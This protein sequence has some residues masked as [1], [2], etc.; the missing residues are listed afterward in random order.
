MPRLFMA[1]TP[2]NGKAQEHSVGRTLAAIPKSAIQTSPGLTPRIFLLHP[3]EHQRA[4]ERSLV[5]Q[6]HIGVLIGDFQQPLPYGP[7]LGFTQLREFLNDFRCAHGEIVSEVSDLSG[8]SVSETFFQDKPSPGLRLGKP[9]FA[10]GYG[11]ASQPSWK[12]N[13]STSTPTTSS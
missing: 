6:G 12:S 7:A 2:M 13:I 9:A 1:L 5:A 3:V 8:Q 10:S 4:L 11:L